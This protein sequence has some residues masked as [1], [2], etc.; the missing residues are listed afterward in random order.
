VAGFGL[1]RRDTP[2]GAG[3]A[4]ATKPW[5]SGA[6]ARWIGEVEGLGGSAGCGL[7]LRSFEFQKAG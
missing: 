5:R 7:P 4:C 1:F 2:V 6:P 3:L